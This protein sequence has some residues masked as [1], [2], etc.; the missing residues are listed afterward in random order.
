MNAATGVRLLAADACPVC[1]DGPRAGRPPRVGLISNANS[2]CN[3][4]HLARV[5]DILSRHAAVRHVI[6]ASTGELHQ[7]VAELAR[8]PIDVLAINGGDG[9][10]ASVLGHVLTHAPFATQPRIVLLP[11]GT[12]N[13]AAATIGSGGSLL[14]A[15]T[16]LSRWLSERPRPCRTLRQPMLR[17]QFGDHGATHHGLFLGAGAV[18][19]GTEYAHR[20]V[21]AL[22]LRGGESLGLTLTRTLWGLRRGDPRFTHAVPVAVTLDDAP[23]LP[24]QEAL[25]L[26]VSSLRRLSLGMC[27]FWGTG[28]GAIRLTLIRPQPERFLRSLPSLLR[29]RPGRHVSEQAGYVSHNAHRLSLLMDGA[30]NLDGEIHHVRREDGAVRIANGGEFTFL[31]P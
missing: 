20:R 30:L 14:R 29:G 16:R 18:I 12:V 11:G 1:A 9:T 5:D 21:H 25:I 24:E 6:T 13:M 2:G 26:L 17:V 28:S 15:A 19:S 31:R 22:G 23:P 7:A 10:A 3:R 4:L 27:P 8:E